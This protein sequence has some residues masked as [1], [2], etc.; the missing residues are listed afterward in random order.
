MGAGGVCF[1]AHGVLP[2]LLRRPCTHAPIPPR[3]NSHKVCAGRPWVVRTP[4]PLFPSAAYPPPPFKL[5]A[6]SGYQIRTV[7]PEGGGGGARTSESQGGVGGARVR[8]PGGGAWGQQGPQN[9]PPPHG[10]GT[11]C[12]SCICR[13]SSCPLPPPPQRLIPLWNV[14]W[15]WGVCSTGPT[16]VW[17]R[18]RGVNP[19]SWSVD[20][21]FHA[22]PHKD[23]A[24]PLPPSSHHCEPSLSI[25]L[26]CPRI[27]RSTPP[28]YA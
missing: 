4:R 9:D 15:Q 16:A 1:C 28:S 22:I 24:A 13:T 7:R 3:D 2:L 20:A 6:W 23:T 18:A 5:R 8:R 10:E 25:A 26:H 12:P 27:C 11:G 21:G 14:Q 17:P 19:R